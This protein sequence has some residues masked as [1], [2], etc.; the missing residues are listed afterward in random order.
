M[1]FGIYSYE[2]TQG[3]RIGSRLLQATQQRADLLGQL[4]LANGRVVSDKELCK[5]V[6]SKAATPSNTVAVQFSR[7]RRTFERLGLELPVAIA[8]GRGRVWTGP[9]LTAHDAFLENM[10]AG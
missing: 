5:L 7:L 10:K 6:G 1:C 8:A 3:F 4:M 9:R 2:P